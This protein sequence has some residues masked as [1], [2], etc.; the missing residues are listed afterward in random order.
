MNNDFTEVDFTE[1]VK[2]KTFTHC[3]DFEEPG[4]QG[5]T[6]HFSDGSRIC[7]YHKQQCCEHVHPTDDSDLPTVKGNYGRVVLFQE[8]T[9]PRV[10]EPSESPSGYWEETFYTME[11]TTGFYDW[12]WEGSSNGYYSISVTTEYCPPPRGDLN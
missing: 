1:L 9:K 4:F 8:R 7:Q 3:D 12:R 11:T 6:F 2:G 10:G 5:I